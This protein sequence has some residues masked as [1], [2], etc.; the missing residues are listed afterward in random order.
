[1]IPKEH[2][3]TLHFDFNQK[4][5]K[6]KRKQN[7]AYHETN[8]FICLDKGTRTFCTL[9]VNS[10]GCYFMK[11]FNERVTRNNMRC[12][13]LCSITIRYR[14]FLNENRKIV[15]SIL[16]IN[17]IFNGMQTRTKRF[18]F[19]GSYRLLIFVVCMLI[20]HGI[21]NHNN[22]TYV[23]LSAHSNLYSIVYTFW[24]F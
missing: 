13:D 24:C 6:W 12:G 11:L 4:P 16:V 7:Y 10:V 19:F 2:L 1:M 17:M 21:Y 23:L 5:T 8:M 14:L 18:L 15:F 22:D 20:A 3:K 9:W